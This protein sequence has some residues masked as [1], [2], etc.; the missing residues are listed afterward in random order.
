MPRDLEAEID[1]E[2]DDAPG[3]VRP[4]SAPGYDDPATNFWRAERE[5]QSGPEARE[6]AERATRT[7]EFHRRD[8]ERDV[9]RS[10]SERATGD[11]WRSKP[12]AKAPE[13]LDDRGKVEWERENDTREAIQ[14]A[15]GR[16]QERT[17]LEGFHR[18][19]AESGT[20]VPAALGRYTQTEDLLRRDPLLGLSFIMRQV[21]LQPHQAIDYLHGLTRSGGPGALFAEGSRGVLDSETARASATMDDTSRVE[22]AVAAVGR[23]QGMREAV[24]AHYDRICELFETGQV[25]RTHN[26]AED[27]VRA[28]HHA[29]SE[30]A[31][32]RSHAAAARRSSRSIT[33]SASGSVSSGRRG[34]VEDDVAASI[35][36]LSGGL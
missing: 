7:E 9:A 1:R 25:Q 34:S 14:E 32:E 5:R 12:P 3:E 27:L 6:R 4:D 22:Y 36:E 21:G 10:R 24:D 16:K 11:G 8:R 15:A 20:T 28:L 30:R 31:R 33:G 35:R 2:F 19:A 18:K 29:Q 17:D 26:P 23:N 13:Y